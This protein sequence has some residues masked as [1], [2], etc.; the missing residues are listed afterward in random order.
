[1]WGVAALLLC[2]AA[3]YAFHKAVAVCAFAQASFRTLSRW[4]AIRVLARK[5]PM[6]KLAGAAI[7]RSLRGAGISRNCEAATSR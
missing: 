5:A 3:A 1:M 2:G 7:A 4:T 6:H